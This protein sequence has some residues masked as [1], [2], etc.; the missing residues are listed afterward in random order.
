VFT[1]G[2]I[3]ADAAA[4]CSEDFQALQGEANRF[5]ENMRAALQ[6]ARRAGVLPG[7]VREAL[8]N[9]RLDFDWER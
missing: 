4:R 1:P 7:T 6:D 3:P 2:A 8:R 9:N 5:R